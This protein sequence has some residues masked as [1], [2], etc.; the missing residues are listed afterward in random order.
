VPEV[1]ALVLHPKG[2]FRAGTELALNSR[3][4]LIRNL[5]EV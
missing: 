2:Q 4:G 1:V 3:L 5:V